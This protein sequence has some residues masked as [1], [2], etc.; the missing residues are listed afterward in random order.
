MENMF[1]QDPSP[2]IDGSTLGG[3]QKDKSLNCAD[4]WTTFG[5]LKFHVTLH[6]NRGQHCF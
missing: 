4:R 5:R 6:M 3:R 2:R 1:F